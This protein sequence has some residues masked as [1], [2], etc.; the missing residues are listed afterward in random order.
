MSISS[1]LWTSEYDVENDLEYNDSSNILFFSHGSKNYQLDNIKKLYMN[2]KTYWLTIKKENDLIKNQNQKDKI[3]NISNYFPSFNE[4]LKNSEC[5]NV[6]KLNY[7]IFSNTK[8]FENYLINNHQQYPYPKLYII[9]SIE[10]LNNNNIKNLDFTFYL[11]NSLINNN[12]YYN[13]FYYSYTDPI[14]SSSSSSSSSSLSFP[15]NFSTNK[16][17]YKKTFEKVFDFPSQYFNGVAFA[18][19]FSRFSLE[20]NSEDSTTTTTINNNNNK[21]TLCDLI[22]YEKENDKLFNYLNLN[23]QYLIKNT[24]YNNT[25]ILSILIIITLF[26]IIIFNIIIKKFFTSSSSSASSS[27]SSSNTT[28]DSKSS[29]TSTT[30]V[31]SSNPSISLSSNNIDNII[32]NEN[33]LKQRNTSS[34]NNINHTYPIYD[35]N[36]TSLLDENESNLTTNESNT[37]TEDSI[38]IS[39]N[40]ELNN[41]NNYLYKTPAKKNKQKIETPFSI[42]TRSMKNKEKEL[43]NQFLD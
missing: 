41:N 25:I 8:N 15:S 21:V 38:T 19:R 39:I 2:L 5:F 4:W 37:L 10:L 29:I 28:N 20:K 40:N 26:I 11:S 36:S 12:D 23:N 9:D 16:A 3:K 18:G 30:N 17:E 24:Q 6:E 43:K 7:N 32:K 31:I 34:N 27:S 22:Q 42:K 1:Y 33:N 35:K 14:E 13:I